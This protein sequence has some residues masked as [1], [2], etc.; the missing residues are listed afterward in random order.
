MHLFLILIVL[1][2]VQGLLFAN[3]SL[4]SSEITRATDK[5]RPPRVPDESNV[6]EEFLGKV[7]KLNTIVNRLTSNK[8]AL[9]EALAEIERT[10]SISDGSGISDPEKERDYYGRN[11]RYIKQQLEKLKEDVR[12][13]LGE[14]TFPLMVDYHFRKMKRVL[15][16]ERVPNRLMKPSSNPMIPPQEMTPLFRPD[17]VEVV[18]KL[19]YPAGH[20]AVEEG[21]NGRPRVFLNA[22]FYYP[23]ELLGD[24]DPVQVVELITEGNDA[25]G[26]PVTKKIP[27]PHPKYQKKFQST[28]SVKVDSKKWLWILD[29][30]RL[31]Y[32]GGVPKIMAY[33]LDAKEDE[34]EVL[35]YE[36]PIEIAPQ[37]SFLND[38]VI[39]RNENGGTILI[40]DTS[41]LAN[42]PALI[43]LQFD[44]GQNGRYEIKNS[45]RLLVG[46]YSLSPYKG[47]MHYYRDHKDREQEKVWKAGVYID[48]AIYSMLK[49]MGLHKHA[50]LLNAFLGNIETFK[51]L[52]NTGG[53]K[54]SLLAK[55]LGLFKS[56][57][58]LPLQIGV[59][60]I[61]LDRENDVVYYGPANRG[62]LYRINLADLLNERLEKDGL[63]A[64]RV[65]RFTEMTTTDGIT[66]DNKRNVYVTD[67]EH[68]AIVKVDSHG[69]IDPIVRGKEFAWPVSIAFGPQGY[70]YFTC[71]SLPDVTSRVPSV[72]RQLGHYYVYRIN[73]RSK[74]GNDIAGTVGH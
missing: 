12:N 65:E 26:T 13:E 64:T 39:I 55:F 54:T 47:Y 23:G 61:T 28:H 20:V 29:Y 67:Q 48:T 32:L 7:K 43:V 36:L 31:R 19:D 70:L 59:D 6:S 22:G 52:R 21:D 41:A 71:Y 46:H 53:S 35:Y 25:G 30:G 27:F 57:N 17:E 15:E 16:G 56:N 68:D 73:L 3:S 1:F 9:E 69:R 60:G 58:F 62:E 5:A 37:G 33:K 50:R 4:D 63:L 66:I 44:Q 51:D 38:M 10:G 45:R 42:K 40:D 11:I 8:N 74:L 72:I 2:T 18:A 14:N 34:Q 49:D 24:K